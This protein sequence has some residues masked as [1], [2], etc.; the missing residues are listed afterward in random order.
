VA[1]GQD[2][3]VVVKVLEYRPAAAKPLESVRAEVT[4]AVRQDAGA[5]AARAAAE[6]ALARLLAGTSFEEAVKGLGVSAAPPMTVGRGDPQL[7]VQL[8][9]AAFAAPQP[10]AG[11]PAYQ[12]LSLDGGNAALLAVLAVHPG[13]PGANPQADQQLISKFVQRHRD[14]DL[15]AYVAEMQRRAKVRR[16]ETVFD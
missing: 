15:E 10:T 8:R 1:L 13:A 14:A 2:R 4:A 5:K 12:A 3:L 6:A 7:P 16:N 9:D 11:K